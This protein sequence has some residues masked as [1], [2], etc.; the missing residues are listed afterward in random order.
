MSERARNYLAEL[1]R[2]SDEELHSSA[3]ELAVDGKRNDAR[4][5]AHIAEIRD[6]TFHPELKYSGLF[7]Y[8]IEELN[9]SE[10]SVARRIQV[11]NVCR[12]FPQILEALFS[13]RL[14]LTGASLIAPHLTR[15]R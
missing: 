9:L 14:H 11:A 6:R 2:R 5:I 8:C 12:E 4:L 10:G 13:G 1:K 7:Q 3:R 15:Q